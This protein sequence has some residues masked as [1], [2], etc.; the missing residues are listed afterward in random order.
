MSDTSSHAL[1]EIRDAVEAAQAALGDIVERLVLLLPPSSDEP[2]IRL[3]VDIPE[4]LHSKLKTAC[5]QNRQKIA[6]VVRAVLEEHL[7]KVE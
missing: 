1:A 2:M 7:L 5:V 6:D 3:T 4:S